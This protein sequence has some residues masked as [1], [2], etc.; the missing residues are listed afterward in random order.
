MRD[1][2]VTTL[3]SRGILAASQWNIPSA[4]GTLLGRRT[5]I[6]PISVTF[7]TEQFTW[8]GITF[9]FY[10]KL[11]FFSFVYGIHIEE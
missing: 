11:A 6:A 8:Y 3:I 9:D 10:F 2:S 1:D 4:H 7:L 5:S